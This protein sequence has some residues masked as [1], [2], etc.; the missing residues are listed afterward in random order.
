MWSVVA[1]LSVCLSVCMRLCNRKAIADCIA[2]RMWNVKQWLYVQILV[3]GMGSSPAKMFIPRSIGSWLRYN[4]A[5]GSFQTIK[6]HSRLLMVLVEI[7]AYNDKF[8]YL[9]PILWTLG[10]PHNLDWL[11]I[12][13]PIV[14]FLF[15]VNWTFFDIYYGFGIMR[16]NVYSWAVFTGVNLLAL[17][18][19]LDRVVPIN[20]SWHQKASD[21]GL[22]D[23][24]DRILLRSVVL[25]Q[26]RSVSYRQTDRQKDRRICRSTYGTCGAL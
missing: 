9:N 24:E 7:S 12:G 23:G 21:T 18:F 26:Y 3:T 15:A 8:G 22:L 20:H 5:A 14:N 13:K 1:F 17:K 25:T 10:V 16:R 4:F 6:L 19:Y 2:R 11:F